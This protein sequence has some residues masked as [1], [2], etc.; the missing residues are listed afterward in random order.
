MY[1]RVRVPYTPPV[2]FKGI[3]V[4]GWHPR[5]PCYP[6]S[7]MSPSLPTC[8]ALERASELLVAI[9]APHDPRPPQVPDLLK[10]LCQKL[11]H[12]HPPRPATFGD[13]DPAAPLRPA[14]DD[15]VTLEVDVVPLQG[16]DLTAAQSRIAPEQQEQMNSLV[17]LGRSVDQALVLLKVVE[18]HLRWRRLKQ[19]DVAR[20]VLDHAPL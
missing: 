11:G 19:L 5:L 17:Q 12:R 18:L 3:P 9:L 10:H 8:F 20:H 15:R 13:R 7:R 4:V 1:L 6:V 2:F 16:D 14:D